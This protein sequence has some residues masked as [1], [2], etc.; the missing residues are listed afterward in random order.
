MKGR[1]GGRQWRKGVV[2]R[3]DGGKE[4]VGREGL[5]RE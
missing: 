1:G 4:A 5:R 3:E 2:G